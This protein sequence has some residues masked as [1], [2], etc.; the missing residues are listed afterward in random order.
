MLSGYPAY[1]YFWAQV[2]PRGAPAQLSSLY[3]YPMVGLAPLLVL[4]TRSTNPYF[5]GYTYPD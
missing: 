3:L 2:S 1:I 5:K 4:L